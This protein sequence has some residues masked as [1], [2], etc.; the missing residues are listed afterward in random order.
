M[1][2]RS[3]LGPVR[4]RCACCISLSASRPASLF[5]RPLPLPT[6][7]CGKLASLPLHKQRLVDLSA[8]LHDVI[9]A[10]GSER[11]LRNSFQD[12]GPRII[13]SLLSSSSLPF[14]TKAALLT[15]GCQTLARQVQSHTELCAANA[16]L[17]DS[18]TVKLFTVSP[19]HYLTKFSVETQSMARC[20]SLEASAAAGPE[21]L[22]RLQDNNAK[23]HLSK[24]GQR[25]CPEHPAKKTQ[26][27]LWG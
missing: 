8:P 23:W 4:R 3:R 17:F 5:V 20:S 21:K 19:R 12:C 27:W 15:N 13:M 2:A 9:F 18:G 7:A 24:A 1:P 25:A 16:N 10:E 22:R 6:L 14:K 11:N 26:H